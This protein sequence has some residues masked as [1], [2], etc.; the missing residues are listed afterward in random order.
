MRFI[1]T[2]NETAVIEY[3]FEADSEKEA[4]EDFEN[5]EVT[6]GR[7]LDSSVEDFSIVRSD[8]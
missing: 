6:D 5:G 1:I 3:E 2:A 7:C 4:R 8:K